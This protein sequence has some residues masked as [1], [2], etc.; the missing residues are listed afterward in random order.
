MSSIQPIHPAQLLAI[1]IYAVADTE[2]PPSDYPYA[3]TGV[4]G[5]SRY[6]FIV[7][8]KTKNTEEIVQELE[9][10]FASHGVPS[11]LMHDRGKEFEA[12]VKLL[13]ESLGVTELKT[14]P[15]S[16][17]SNGNVERLHRELEAELVRFRAA[18]KTQ[19]PLVWTRYVPAILIKLRS[20]INKSTKFSPYELMGAKSPIL[21]GTVPELDDTQYDFTTEFGTD[22]QWEN[23][24]KRLQEKRAV[25][26]TN[27]IE[28]RDRR[29]EE[30]NS[31]RP[32]TAFQVGD[33]VRIAMQNRNKTS[34]QV[35]E[36]YQVIEVPE[37]GQTYR[38]QNPRNGRTRPVGI[39]EMTKTT[40]PTTAQVNTTAA[41]QHQN[42]PVALAEISNGDTTTYEVIEYSSNAKAAQKFKQYKNT[43]PHSQ[44][45]MAKWVKNFGHDLQSQGN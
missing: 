29:V 23:W 33:W 38:V 27:D 12:E 4:Y 43:R 10:I 30:M 40:A 21:T 9:W 1:D 37:E 28:S 3:L 2:G 17:H 5:F 20:T 34:A 14:A 39:T 44:A 45:S 35:S 26:L 19:S 41:G 32:A 31:N 24:I 15:K 11:I 25:A 7:P 13:C 22:Q 16:P 8:I 36:P 42:I 6:P 18:T